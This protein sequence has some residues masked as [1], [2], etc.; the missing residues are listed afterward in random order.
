MLL[1]HVHLAAP[2]LIMLIGGYGGGTLNDV[3]IINIGEEDGPTCPKPADFPVSTRGQVGTI[4]NGKTFI[5]GGDGISSCHYYTFDTGEW[6]RTTDM[7]TERWYAASVLMDNNEWWITGGSPISA[8]PYSS[9][10]IFKDGLFSPGP[11]LPSPLYFHCLLTINSTH[12]F[13]AGGLDGHARQ[14]KAY[15]FEW[16]SGTW[17]TLADMKYAR[18]SHCCGLAGKNIVVVGGVTDDDSGEATSEIF[19]TDSLTWSMGPGTP[20]GKLF[21]RAPTVPHGNS[22]LVVGGYDESA[23]LDT[24]YEFDATNIAWIQREERLETARRYLVALALP[25]DVAGC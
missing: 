22:F 18:D 5:C 10:L 9:T 17:T 13:L 15:M 25:S 11:D 2:T 8:N 23:H 12:A 6:I 1:F 4:L 24:I 7:D 20:N 16:T 19:S 21:Y 3:E 14:Q